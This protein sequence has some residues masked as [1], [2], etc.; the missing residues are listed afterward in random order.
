M[1]KSRVIGKIATL[2]LAAAL[3]LLLVSAASAAA[4][5]LD[6]AANANA[7]AS[8]NAAE[9]SALMEVG[10]AAEQTAK[11]AELQVAVKS[12]WRT[13]WDKSWPFI[14]TTVGKFW[15]LVVQAW[16]GLTTLGKSTTNLN[17]NVN[18]AANANA[19]P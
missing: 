8:T 17:A 1:T 14:K 4:I 18:A 12:I 5:S 19:A 2:P 10:A 6:A 16:T 11:S 3:M 9:S 15:N 13:A 7:N